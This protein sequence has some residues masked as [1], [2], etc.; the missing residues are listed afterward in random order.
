MM[1]NKL[2]FASQKGDLVGG[3]RQL[4][5]NRI[6]IVVMLLVNIFFKVQM[7]QNPVD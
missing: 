5:V 3:G 4:V 1:E 7:D 6:K 2:H